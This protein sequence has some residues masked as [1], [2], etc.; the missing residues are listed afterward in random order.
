MRRITPHHLRVCVIPPGFDGD[1]E[2]KR[3]EFVLRENQSAKSMGDLLSKHN[4]TVRVT[5]LNKPE[6]L[7]DSDVLAKFYAYVP[8]SFPGMKLTLPANSKYNTE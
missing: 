6:V 2:K 1:V 5:I 3:I 7:Q 4:A 8:L